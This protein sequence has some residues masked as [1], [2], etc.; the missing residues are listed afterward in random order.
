MLVGG[1][2]NRVPEGLLGAA[3]AENGLFDFLRFCNFTFGPAWRSEFG[4]PNLPGDFDFMYPIS[5]VHNV[6][7]GPVLP[8]VMIMTTRDDERVVPMHSYKFISQLQHAAPN[9]PNPLLLRISEKGGHG[10]YQSTDKLLKD[11]LDRLGFIVQA[12]GLVWREA[13]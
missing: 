2:I 13:N 7:R 4:D 8:A 9:N 6:P 5:P 3:I 12:L 10:N 11:A 1:C